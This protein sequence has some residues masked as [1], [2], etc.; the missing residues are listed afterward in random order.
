[1]AVT[2]QSLKLRRIA[3]IKALPAGMANYDPKIQLAA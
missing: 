1:M 3:G 2:G